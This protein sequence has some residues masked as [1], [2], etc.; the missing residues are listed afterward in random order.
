MTSDNAPDTRAETPEARTEIIGPPAVVK[1]PA[2][3]PPAHDRPDPWRWSKPALLLLV[4]LSAAAGGG[5]WRF[6][7]GPKL[8]P[9]IA[10]GNGRLEAVW[11]TGD[12]SGFCSG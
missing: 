8:P 5:Y 3:M 11:L 12:L 9:G 6:H 2:V 4:L 7:S 1:L 10:Y